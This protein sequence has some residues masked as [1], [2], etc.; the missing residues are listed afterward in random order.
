MSYNCFMGDQ[1]LHNKYKRFK[2]IYEKVQKLKTQ[3]ECFGTR[4]LRRSKQRKWLNGN[5]QFADTFTREK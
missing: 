3:S 5:A 1:V 4:F 2:A